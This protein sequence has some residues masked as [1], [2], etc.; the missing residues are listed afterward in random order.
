MARLR[1]LNETDKTV[2]I[3]IITVVDDLILKI[4]KFCDTLASQEAEC[5]NKAIADL[6]YINI[7]I[8]EWK[9]RNYWILEP[10]E[11]KHFLDLQKRVEKLMG[12]FMLKVD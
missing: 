8:Y 9:Q 12:E 1:Q 11:R 10:K 6:P 4:E 3:S 7:A 5:N 2:G